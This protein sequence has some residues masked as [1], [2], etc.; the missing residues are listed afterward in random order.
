MA[1]NK[2]P[3]FG[4]MAAAALAA[5][6]SRTEAQRAEAHAEEL[7]TLC[8]VDLKALSAAAGAPQARTLAQARVACLRGL[9]RL[10]CALET[11]DAAAMAEEAQGVEE[12]MEESVAAEWPHTVAAAHTFSAADLDTNAAAAVEEHAPAL[13]GGVLVALALRQGDAASEEAALAAAAAL[14]VL[15]RR[16]SLGG[17]AATARAAVAQL[18]DG[19]GLGALVALLPRRSCHAPGALAEA[20]GAC[21]GPPP[22]PLLAALTAAPLLAQLPVLLGGSFDARHPGWHGALCTAASAARRR[23]A[24]G[25]HAAPAGVARRGGVPARGSSGADGSV[26]PCVVGRP[27]AG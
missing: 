19:G 8:A 14:R 6:F 21:G 4:A 20:M 13:L 12:S 17:A 7:R 22:P 11:D 26:I 9:L 25:G 16:L 27:C 15:F 10:Y 18:A 5:R 24:R 2:R 3:P 23:C 1:I